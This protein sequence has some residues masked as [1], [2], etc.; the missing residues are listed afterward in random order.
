LRGALSYTSRQKG[1]FSPIRRAFFIFLRE[2]FA[3]T[4]GA[5]LIRR[6][7]SN[8]EKSGDANRQGFRASIATMLDAAANAAKLAAVVNLL[9]PNSPEKQKPAEGRALHPVETGK[10]HVWQQQL[11]EIASGRQAVIFR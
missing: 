7:G 3:S 8:R 1:E 2:K 11:P 10:L 9:E 6:Q 4:A 5:A